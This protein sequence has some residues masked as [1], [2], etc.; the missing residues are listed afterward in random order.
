MERND[1]REAHSF[2]IS[3]VHVRRGPPPRKIKR[4][5]TVEIRGTSGSPTPIPMQLNAPHVSPACSINRLPLARCLFLAVSY[6]RLLSLSS[7]A[8]TLSPPL[9]FVQSRLLAL[10]PSLVTEGRGGG[11]EGVIWLTE[12]SEGKNRW[13]TRCPGSASRV[14]LRSRS[15][16]PLD[17]AA[18][19]VIAGAPAASP[20]CWGGAPTFH[21]FSL[22]LTCPARQ[23]LFASAFTLF[24]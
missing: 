14:C 12:F 18:S 23:L 16:C 2:L 9:G 19:V 22:L 13:C 3:R 20:S 21:V 11:S 10:F 6:Y 5:S 17:R 8:L 4:S 1:R 15:R 24:N 7:S